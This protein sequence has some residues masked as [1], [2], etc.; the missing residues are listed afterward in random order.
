M[1]GERSDVDALLPGLDLFLMTSLYEGLPC[2][3]IEA[4]RIGLPVVAT[5][6]NG[7]PEIVISGET[8]ILVPPGRPADTARA[9]RYLLERPGEAG[10]MGLAGR[11]L[12]AGR[13]TAQGAATALASLYEDALSPRTAPWSLSEAS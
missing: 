5:A 12:V 9:V 1:T 3:L 2:A 10:R 8:G 11:G 4:M 6:V 7:V 13:F